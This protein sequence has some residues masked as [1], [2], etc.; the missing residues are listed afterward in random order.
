[1]DYK[2][3]GDE[4]MK[5]AVLL[6]IM[7]MIF[8]GC[9]QKTNTVSTDRSSK[10][11]SKES[12]MSEDKDITVGSKTDRGMIVD[13]VYHDDKQGDIHFSS[14]FP[15]DY[16]GNEEYALFVTNPGWEGE[17]PQGL[18]N[19]LGE[20]FPFEARKYN[21]RMIILS[22]QLNDWG[23]TSALD[24]LALIHHFIDHYAIDKNRIYLHGY[25]GGGET[26]SLMLGMEPELFA[27]VLLNSTQWDSD[28]E[29]LVNAET[30][31]RL[32]VGEDDSYYG[33][34]PLKKA[35]QNIHDAYV[36]KGLSEEEINKILVLDVKPRSWFT[37]RGYSDEHDG[38]NAF[39]KDAETMQWLFSQ[40]KQ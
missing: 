11:V 3:D 20:D 9:A 15:D 34:E 24:S 22:T 29:P 12:A 6:I 19:N 2:E 8:A 32:A 5:K 40:V 33:S 1:M 35:Y 36:K 10:E 31:L 39:A 18:G 7:S 26:G 37:E 16:D 27:G 17:Y 23:N 13:N 30:P 4:K 21:D 28:I 14:Y 38:G 25:S